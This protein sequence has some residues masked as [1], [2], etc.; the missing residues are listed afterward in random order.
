MRGK[1]RHSTPTVRHGVDSYV[2]TEG[3]RLG[4]GNAKTLGLVTRDGRKRVTSLETE[5]WT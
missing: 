5:G 2:V 3:R 4:R 1:G